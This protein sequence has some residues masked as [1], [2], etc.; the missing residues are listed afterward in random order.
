LGFVLAIVW[1][2]I[3]KGWVETT[4]GEVC[5][6]ISAKRIFAKEYQAVGIPFFRGK[7]VTEKYKGNDISTELFI[8]EE[9]YNEIKKKYGAPVAEDI[10]L[11]SVG[12][13][14]NPY[15][16]EKNYKFYFKD[17]NLTWFRNFNRWFLRFCFELA[18]V[19]FCRQRL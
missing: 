15:F 13:L 6:I 4:L 5:E 11:T 12:T 3:P 1:Q 14:G 17:G 2:S 19:L 16:V 7:E 18:K 9:K 10:L 8:S